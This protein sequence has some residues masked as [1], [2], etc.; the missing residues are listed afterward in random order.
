M[1]ERERVAEL[2]RQ[3]RADDAA[4]VP[5]HKGHLGRR[6]EFGRDDQVAF[7]FARGVVEDDE[8]LARAEG[9][10]AAFDRVEERLV[11]V[12]R[13][14]AI[15]AREGFGVDTVRGDRF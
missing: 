12:G 8:E 1:R 2:A 10:Y 11:V 15:C 7:V 4:G 3:G 13:D 5:D 6:H 9:L 14:A